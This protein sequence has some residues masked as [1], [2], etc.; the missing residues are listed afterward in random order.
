MAEFFEDLY[1]GKTYETLGVT[2]TKEAIVRF[3]LEY[4]FQPF[5]VDEMAA[6]KSMFGGLIA[7]GLHTLC[8]AFRLCNQAGL[9]TGNAVAGLGIDELRFVRPVRPDDTL[10]VTLTI[11][12]CRPSATRSD[13]GVVRWGVKCLNQVGEVVLSAVLANLVLRASAARGAD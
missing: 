5:H 4:D 10:R 1:P 2:I 7:S 8:L 9:F 12:D 6:E 11:K 13:V 3:G